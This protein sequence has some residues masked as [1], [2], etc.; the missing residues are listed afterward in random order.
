MKG[1]V[2]QP[3]VGTERGTPVENKLVIDKDNEFEKARGYLFLREKN[4]SLIRMV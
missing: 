3:M 1:A 4:R 2:L